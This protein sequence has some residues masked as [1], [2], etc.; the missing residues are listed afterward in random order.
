MARTATETLA[1]EVENVEHVTSSAREKFIAHITVTEG[2]EWVGDFFA[3]FVR[4]HIGG[5]RKYVADWDNL[6]SG[7]GIYVDEQPPFWTVE[8]VADE[9]NGRFELQTIE[10]LNTGPRDIWIWA[11]LMACECTLGR[12]AGPPARLCEK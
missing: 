11:K 5:E 4:Q 12:Q 1:A 3:E 10:A 7:N 2:C 8:E 6:K 9:L